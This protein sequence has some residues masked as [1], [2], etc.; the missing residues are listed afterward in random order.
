MNC[1]RCNKKF[2]WCT[3][4][5]WDEGLHPMSEG[6]CSEECLIADGGRTYASIVDDE[7]EVEKEPV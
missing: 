1:K 2:H 7:D 3:S 5:G 6:Y 4:C